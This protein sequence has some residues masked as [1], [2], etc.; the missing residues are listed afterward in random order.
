MFQ[1]GGEE[2]LVTRVGVVMLYFNGDDDYAWFYGT[3]WWQGMVVVVMVM[4][5]ISFVCV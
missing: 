5:V 2:D 1:G 4:A 3:E